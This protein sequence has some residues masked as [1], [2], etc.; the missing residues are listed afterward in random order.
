MDH[1]EMIQIL[2]SGRIHRPEAK[3]R[4][5]TGSEEERA[6]RTDALH[7]LGM[8]FI[9]ARKCASRSGTEHLSK[10]FGVGRL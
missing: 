5:T 1:G 8:V 9:P 6:V 7:T 2:Y 10:L 3:R 4:V